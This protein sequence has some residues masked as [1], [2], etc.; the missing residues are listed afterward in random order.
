MRAGTREDAHRVA[1][2]LRGEH[3][4]KP[5]SPERRIKAT[6]M[7]DLLGDSVGQH[8]DTAS[9]PTEAFTAIEELNETGVNFAT[10]QARAAPARWRCLH[11]RQ[12]RIV[13]VPEPQAS[14]SAGQG[15]CVAVPSEP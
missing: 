2:E 7:E 5:Q 8:I 10:P 9:A 4:S 15:Q 3:N 12:Q 13:V 11:K 6:H 1:A 14:S